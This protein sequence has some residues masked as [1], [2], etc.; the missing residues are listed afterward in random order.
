MGIKLKIWGKH[1]CFTRPEMRV[2]RVSYD[3][4]TPTAAK[5]VIESIYWKPAIKWFVDRIHV[6]NRI[7]FVS[8][9]RNE[10]NKKVTSRDIE[11]AKNNKECY[12]DTD[13]VR[14]QRNSLVLQD[15][16]YIIEAHFE[17]TGEEE[18][19]P[20]KHYNAFLRRAR[21]GQCFNQPYMGCREFPAFFELLEDNEEVPESY[22]SGQEID[23]GWMLREINYK[24]MSPCFFRANMK[25]GVIEIPQKEVVR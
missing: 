6:I 21:K 18:S 7:N 24:D 17:E 19:H 13:K 2:E 22:Y 23:L 5:G 8:F 9:K 25:D 16:F 11:N 15:V 10:V 3:A 4:I 12:I 20:E 14:V 1:A